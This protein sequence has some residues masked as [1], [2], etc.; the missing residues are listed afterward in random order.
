MP[1]RKMPDGPWKLC[2]DAATFDTLRHDKEFQFL[3][4]LSRMVLM[5]KLSID[6]MAGA[7]NDATPKGDR[8]RS[9]G[10]WVMCGTLHEI[11]EF[12]TKHRDTWGGLT[13]YVEAFKLFDDPS[14]PDAERELLDRIRNRAAYHFDPSLPARVLPDLTSQPVT[15][16]AGDSKERLGSSYEL[17]EMTALAFVFD[18]AANLDKVGDRFPPFFETA[19]ALAFRFARLAENFMIQ[20]LLARGFRYEAVPEDEIARRPT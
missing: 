10:F 1:T 6:V 17:S 8:Q 11:L 4:T 12:D 20:R 7:G 3:V 15:F 13:A 18:G 19:K 2:C 14:L 5:L 9:S 16:M